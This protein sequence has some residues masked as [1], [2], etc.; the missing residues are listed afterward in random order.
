VNEL[1]IKEIAGFVELLSMNSN[2]NIK[3]SIAL[4]WN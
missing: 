4:E 3:I 2:Y 1:E